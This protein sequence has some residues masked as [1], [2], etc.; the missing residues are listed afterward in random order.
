MTR[1]ATR[2]KTHG[3]DPDVLAGLVQVLRC[4][5]LL[6]ESL[7]AHD[8]VVAI[9]P[10]MKTSVAHTLFLT[11][12]YAKIFET[13]ERK[14]YYLDA[15]SWAAMGQV[16]R[17]ITLLRTRLNQPEIG[18]LMSAMMASLLRVLEGKGQDVAAIV[19]KVGTVHEPEA[20]FYFARHAGMS[21]DA[22]SAVHLVERARLGGFW[23]SQALEHDAAFARIRDH[24]KFQHEV[25]ESRKL[26]SHSLHALKTGLGEDMV[27]RWSL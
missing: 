14:G 8:R 15:A 24:V 12:D 5:G 27:K 1:L 21:H 26:E 10:A 19:E 22:E 17:A 16:D 6:G 11:G 25:R 4:C 23:S 2:L 13:Y 9:D 7:A 3:E 18:P 20:I